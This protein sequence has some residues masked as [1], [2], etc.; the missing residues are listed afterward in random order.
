MPNSLEARMRVVE[1][2]LEGIDEL[3]ILLEDVKG[4]L[5]V[6]IKIG[7]G[8]KWIAGVVLACSGITWACKHFGSAI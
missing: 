2:K 1:Q 4:A 8:V 5:R 3:V 6:F 7:K